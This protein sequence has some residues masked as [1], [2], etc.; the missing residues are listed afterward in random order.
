V[1]PTGPPSNL[2]I[3]IPKEDPNGPVMPMSV[4]RPTIPDIFIAPESVI[5]APV[6]P[7]PVA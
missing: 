7:P 3:L 1:Y 4:V 2:L 5:M 6:E